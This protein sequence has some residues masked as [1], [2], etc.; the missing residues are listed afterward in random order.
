MR[1]EF[2]P[3]NLMPDSAHEGEARGTPGELARLPWWQ[4]AIVIAMLSAVC[5]AALIGSLVALQ[6]IF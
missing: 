1:Q 6:S 5:W 3:R 2:A 4:A